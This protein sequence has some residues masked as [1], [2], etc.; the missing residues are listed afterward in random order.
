MKTIREYSIDLIENVFAEV[1][2]HRSI[3]LVHWSK[4]KALAEDYQIQG[5]FSN[6]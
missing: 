6:T 2:F 3:S 4:Q 1:C 5:D